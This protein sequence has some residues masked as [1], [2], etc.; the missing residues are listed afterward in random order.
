MAKPFTR[1]A[2]WAFLAL[3]LSAPLD[4]AAA[5]EELK[6]LTK[7]RDAPFTSLD[8]AAQ[9]E[10]TASDLTLIL[11]GTLLSYSYLERP[12]KLVP[13]LLAKMPELAADKVTYTLT[14]KKGVV[15]QDNKCFEGGKG[16]E[17]TAD[18]V[19]Y[20]LK[21]YADAN[22]NHK[23]WFVME[24]AVVGLD[25]F[26][27]ETEK[28]GKSP[29]HAMV[30]VAGL[31]KLDRYTL[32][33]RLTHEN[34][35]FL[36]AMALN[37][38]AIVPMEAVRTY[39]DR[40]DV[41]PVG[42][43]PFSLVGP[44]ERKGVLRFL[45][46]PNFYG[47]YPSLGASGDSEKGLLKAAGR[48]LP[49]VDIIDMPLIEEPQP[50]ALKF[51]SG[52]LDW[53]GIDR[54][55]FGRLVVRSPDGSFRLADE[56]A[57]KFDLYT[58]P[59]IDLYYFVFNLKDPL[60]GQ[61]KKLRQAF[62]HLFDT[63]GLIDVLLNGRGKKL[64]SLVPLDLRGNERE[65]GA[66]YLDYDLALGKKLLAEAGYP[67]GKGLP[68]VVM[69]YPSTGADRREQFDFMRARFAAAGVQL[70]P[71]LTDGPTFV[72][73]VEASNFMLAE[74]SWLADY[75]DAEDFYQLLYSKN[76]A[77]GPNLSSF[78]NAAYDKAYEASRFM[79]DGPERLRQ[80][81]IMNE[82]VKEEVPIVVS[83]NSLRFGMTQKWLSNF[84]R[85]LL[86]SE[87]PYLDI[88]MARKKKGL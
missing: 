46:N 12:Y 63:R 32:T 11:Y 41:N 69:R 35:L 26:R 68:P 62:A 48:K 70:K 19:L 72:K 49:L 30:E 1:F 21:R 66:T 58:T 53:R 16:R 42:T 24:G 44:A 79:V 20:S 75:P 33:I 13:E 45:K 25:A 73:N 82:I 85:N 57:P 9:F 36:Y 38:T 47:V 18:D 71:D 64:Q 55:N 65:T 43:G 50:A 29:D 54:A 81:K 37:S 6:V 17:L 56:F 8:P 3:W 78:S 14:L 27:A 67:N 59:G 39:G 84:K 10:E 61:N 7:S 34:P 60:F 31:R 77:P 86:A 22:I 52:E 28:A 15:F 74:Y 5:A 88:D 40:F 76:S 23:S 87:L 51:L 83:R 2:A 4:S 80:F